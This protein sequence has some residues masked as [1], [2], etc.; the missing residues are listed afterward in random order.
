MTCTKTPKWKSLHGKTSLIFEHIYLNY[1]IYD[2]ICVIVPTNSL[3]EELFYKFLLFN[4]KTYNKYKILTSPHKN[5][6]NSL[7][8]LTPEKYLLLNESD[9]IKFDLIVI[10]ES[11]KI[12]E[13]EDEI[14]YNID[15]ILNTRSSKYRMVFELCG[16]RK[17]TR[18]NSSH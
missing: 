13:S 17:S 8:I 7:Y 9:N 4:R 15:D 2:N 18:L 12:E 11:Y 5:K 3:E 1:Q 14:K 10:D 6:G 16:D